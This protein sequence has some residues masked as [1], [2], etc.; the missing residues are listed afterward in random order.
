M[1]FLSRVVFK[2]LFLFLIA[3]LLFGAWIEPHLG[4]ISAYNYLFPGRAR[5]PFGETPRE[6]Y[7]F[8]LFD[9]DAMFAAHQYINRPVGQEYRVILVGDSSVWG[10]LLRPEQTLAG[11]LN[12][13][14]LMTSGGR[15]LRFY[16]LGYPTISL[17]KDLLILDRAMQYQPD[18]V[19]WLT[20]LEAFPR[21]KQLAVPLLQNNPHLTADLL[22]RY[23]L[24][25][26]GAPAQPAFFER[27][28]IGQR[29]NLADL[30]RLQVYGVLWAATG[31][32]QAYPSDYPRA[33]VD[34]EADATFHGK[35]DLAQEDLAL[36]VL[37]AGQSAAG[38][39]PILL[40]NEPIMRSSGA[41]STLRYNFYYPRRAYDQYR[42]YLS[43][44]VKMLGMAYLDAWDLVP[45]QE[46]TNSAIHLNPDA[47][48]RLAQQISA[49]VRTLILR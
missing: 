40:V 34:L 22:Q 46:F 37:A 38:R 31:V 2:A 20:T 7:N 12:A 4:R 13:F 11:R 39:V 10:T 28:I 26:S 25:F 41:N 1:K 24:N 42:G 48:A 5:F 29:K 9:L 27:T 43:Q 18:L 23:Q 6:A 14:H 32:D 8:S 15:T 21:E 44:Q 19:I 45:Q 17:T 35:A 49:Q 47:T 3:N 33:Q 36:D 16:N 30:L